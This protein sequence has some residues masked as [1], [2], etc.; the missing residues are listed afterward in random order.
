MYEFLGRRRRWSFVVGRWSFAKPRSLTHRERPA[1]DD[2]R[3]A[4]LKGTFAGVVAGA[5]VRLEGTSGGSVCQIDAELAEFG[6]RITLRRVVGQQIL[7]A[8]FV[9]DLLEGIIDLRRG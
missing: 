7:G 4:S 2:Q 3:L 6:K 8:Q 9:A 1:T 5:I